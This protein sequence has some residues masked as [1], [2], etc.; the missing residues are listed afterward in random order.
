VH[1]QKSPELFDGQARDFDQRAGLPAESCHQ[2]AAAVLEIGEVGASDVIVEVGAG[3]GQIGVQLAASRRYVGF[4]LSVE[5]LRRFRAKLH[6]PPTAHVLVRADANHSWPVASRS[7][8][9]IFGS[10]A[11]HL[12][13]RDH[14][15][16]E[17]FRVAMPAGATLIPGR[18]ER[19]PWSVRARMA[20]KMRSLLRVRGLEPRGD[21][22]HHLIVDACVRRG[23]VPLQPV[24][25]AVWVVAV[26]A[27]QS[28]EAWQRLSG[29]GGIEVPDAIRRAVVT[30]LTEWAANSF[31][32]LDRPLES[33]EAY[34][35]RPV[36]LGA[37]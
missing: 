19:D 16:E 36:R 28:L 26:S 24:T 3:T 8:R 13:D 27:R 4:D 6:S 12:L 20:K 30:E 5:M 33:Q 15:A 9:A 7:A 25:A 35:L 21:R 31:G 23:A 32:G 2:I 37:D 17:A 11:L 34:V 29:L 10:R 22:Q 1:I 18:V 14:V